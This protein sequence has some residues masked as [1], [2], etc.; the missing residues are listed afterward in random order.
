[1][2]ADFLAAQSRAPGK[3]FRDRIAGDADIVTGC[4]TFWSAARDLLATDTNDAPGAIDADDDAGRALI[5]FSLENVEHEPFHW[6]LGFFGLDGL[7]FSALM[8]GLTNEVLACSC[9]EGG[10]AFFEF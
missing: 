3:N 7:G 8:G 2:T 5:L 9:I 4:K 1:L 6:T 10:K